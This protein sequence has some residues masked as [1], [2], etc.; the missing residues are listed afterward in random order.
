M[1]SGLFLLICYYEHHC[2]EHSRGSPGALGQVH[3]L[4]STRL[5]AL[6]QVRLFG[7]R[8]AFSIRDKRE[9]THGR[10]S[11]YEARVCLLV[12]SVA[13]CGPSQMSRLGTS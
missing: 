7:F 4:S 5:P 12:M 8:N 13:V 1:V 9:P 3:M 10:E 2:C 11:R 6:L